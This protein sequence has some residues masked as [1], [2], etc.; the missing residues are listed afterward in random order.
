MLRR[1]KASQVDHQRKFIGFTLSALKYGQKFGVFWRFFLNRIFYYDELA[2]LILHNFMNTLKKFYEISEI[3]RRIAG[4]AG[5]KFYSYCVRRRRNSIM[6][7]GN[8]LVSGR[9]KVFYWQPRFYVIF[10]IPRR[11]FLKFC[12][13]LTMKTNFIH[14][15]RGGGGGMCL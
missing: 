4:W 10:Y 11:N 7:G 15:S 13:S 14:A 1:Y 12:N 5:D 2:T 8:G 3:I 9:G 6:G